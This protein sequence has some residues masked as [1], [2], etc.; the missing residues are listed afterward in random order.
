MKWAFVISLALI[1]YTYL[2]YPLLLFIRSQFR[3]RP[4]RR[5]PIEPSVSVVIAMHNEAGALQQ[6]LQNLAELNYPSDRLQIIIV[7]DGSAD[8]TY[9]LLANSP[10]PVE[11]ICL[12]TRQ[13][14]A[15]ALNH[16]VQ[17]AKGEIVVFMDTRQRILPTALRSL[18]SCFADSSVG[19]AS[20]ELVLEDQQQPERGYELNLY[21]KIEK[22][23]RKLESETC[24]AVG[25]TGALYAVRRQLI[26]VLPPAT[27]LDDVFIPMS[28]V[29]LGHR[30]VVD[31]E[32]IVVDGVFP[33]VGVEFHRKVRTLMG[34]YQ[35]LRLAPW[36][37]TP[38]NK[39]LWEFT[40]HKLLRLIVP[41]ALLGAF[42]SS[43]G[44]VGSGFGQV[45]FVAQVA[46]Y[47]LALLG[48][49][50]P[51]RSSVR[52][53]GVAFSFALLNTAAVVGLLKFLTGKKDVWAR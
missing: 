12:P 3:S 50:R 48:L 17:R 1:A 51:V 23:V 41:F 8:A 6:K 28:V 21:W 53:S 29:K 16:G 26:P 15:V 42:I 39:L 14:K 30:V 47:L 34:N 18:V 9:E 40:S 2:G 45:M 19:A 13:G 35:L 24:S 7:S 52:A 20:G 36:L 43:W 22:L 25:A 5:G 38:E 33:D 4:V 46:F 27:I 10:V 37:L 49:A 11:R 44:M 31:D 32:A